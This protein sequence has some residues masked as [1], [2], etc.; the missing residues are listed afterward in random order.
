MG[1]FFGIRRGKFCGRRS[2]LSVRRW[3]RKEGV[4]KDETGEEML[5]RRDKG[6]K[7]KNFFKLGEGE[8]KKTDTK[9]EK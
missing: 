3:L 5:L 1:D 4:K 9:G 2:R 7:K 8:F 6:E